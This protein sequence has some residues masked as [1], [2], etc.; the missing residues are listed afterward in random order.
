MKNVG[1]G[2]YF[3]LHYPEAALSP[4]TKVLYQG[5]VVGTV[6]KRYDPLWYAVKIT[7]P[8]FDPT[9]PRCLP[10]ISFQ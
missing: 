8:G 3:Q 7:D 2:K 5:K 4:G 9:D 10:G 6:I 1:N